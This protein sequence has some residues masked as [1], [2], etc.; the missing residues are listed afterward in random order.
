MSPGDN[1]YE[2]SFKCNMQQM[3]DLINS[4]GKE[5]ALAKIPIALADS[6]T[7]EHLYP[8]PDTGTRSITVKEYNQVVDELVQDV[9]NNIV[10]TPPD[11][12]TYFKN[13][14]TDEYFD[15]IHPNGTGYRSIAE[16]WM[17]VLTE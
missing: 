13:N 8:D 15:N 7:S 5:V 6:A 4:D 14:Y 2:G 3:I 1:G 10:A 12:Y 17:N 11:F 9:A 16:M